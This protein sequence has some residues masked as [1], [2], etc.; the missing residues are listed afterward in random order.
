MINEKQFKEWCN[1]LNILLDYDEKFVISKTFLAKEKIFLLKENF[2]LKKS[3]CIHRRNIFDL[4]SLI[5]SLIELSNISLNKKIF[6]ITN[7]IRIELNNIFRTNNIINIIAILQKISEILD[8]YADEIKKHF[9]I[10]KQSDDFYLSIVQDTDN[11]L[12]ISRVELFFLQKELI[13]DI[14]LVNYLEK[15][16][17][18]NF[19][20]INI[21]LFNIFYI[22]Y[23]NLYSD[24]KYFDCN[25]L[26]C[27]TD[28]IYISNYTRVF[29]KYDNKLLKYI[30][31]YREL[32]IE[33]DL[34]NRILDKSITYIYDQEPYYLEAIKKINSSNLIDHEKMCKFDYINKLVLNFNNIK[35]INEIY[36]DYDS[37]PIFLERI[38]NVNIF[39]NTPGFVLA[40]IKKT[41]FL[42]LMDVATSINTNI[43]YN[44]VD[45]LTL[46]QYIKKIENN[47]EDFKTV[48]PLLISK[49]NST[50]L[51]C[52]QIYDLLLEEENY[53]NEMT[54]SQVF[55][56]LISIIDK[57]KHRNFKKHFMN[58][59]NLK[60]ECHIDKEFNNLSQY[61]SKNNYKKASLVANNILTGL[62][63]S[64]YYNSSFPLLGVKDIPLISNKL[65]N[66]IQ[67]Q[68]YSK[69]PFLDI[70]NLKKIINCYDSFWK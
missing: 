12:S 28:H 17:I 36:I 39:E 4:I 31:E 51:K 13:G 70:S 8:S 60:I 1:N 57:Y 2:L 3:A 41:Y 15:I 30:S 64:I 50:L 45:F 62:I 33:P 29:K 11:M 69:N 5:I 54:S 25:Y 47:I 43:K 32:N 20:P 58:I 18:D 59:N 7:I 35:S 68:I 14:N 40:E 55:Y 27:K 6:N 49:M 9:L 26:I 65:Y 24:L 23:L 44:L 38:N 56:F 42:I 66:N 63:K 10:K 61:L 52:K 34:I 16:D 19:L 46:E 53:L 48:A 67:D 37:L 22:R 21:K